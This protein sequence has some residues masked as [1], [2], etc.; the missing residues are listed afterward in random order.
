MN[1]YLGYLF[2]VFAAFSWGV[3]GV[4]ARF[5]LETGMTPAEIAF[6]RTVFGCL[7]FGSVAI[8]RKQARLH[9][10]RDLLGFMA[11]GIICLALLFLCYMAAVESGGAA[12][13]VVLQYTAPAWV[14]LFARILFMEPLTKAKCLA[15]FV[16]LAGVAVVSLS[17]GAGGS[18]INS[19]S[20]SLGLLSG[21]LYAV[22][23]VATKKFVASYSPFTIFGYGFF[24][25]ALTLLPLVQ[26]VDKSPAD[27]GILLLMG[28]ACTFCPFFFYAAGVKRIEAST[29][30]VIATFEP[31]VA[32]LAAWA[33]WNETFSLL[34]V[35]GIAIVIGAVL[36]LVLSS[37]PKRSARKKSGAP[38]LVCAPAARD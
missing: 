31:V 19:L 33:V 23:S 26:F 21:L 24:F 8:A 6:W 35:A 7:L 37:A 10:A 2:I 28:A 25:A 12:L 16:S 1:M 13:T 36:M 11:F 34:G 5:L 30:S 27:W 15:V 38:A 29:A 17:G 3:L 32:T 4:L 14:A 22:Q 20:V 18:N 9:A